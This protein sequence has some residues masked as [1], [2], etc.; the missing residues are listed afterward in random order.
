MSEQQTDSYD[1]RPVTSKKSER[2]PF[3]LCFS[4]NQQIGKSDAC[5]SKTNADFVTPKFYSRELEDP[6]NADVSD[7]LERLATEQDRKPRNLYQLPLLT[8][9][10]YGWWHDKGIHP[11]D[12]RFD[13]HKRTSDLVS[14]QMKIYAEDRSVER[15]S[16]GGFWYLAEIRKD[17]QAGSRRFSPRMSSGIV[18]EHSRLHEKSEQ[19]RPS[20]SQESSLPESK[21]L[22]LDNGCNNNLN[23]TLNSHSQNNTKWPYSG[24]AS[25]IEPEILEDMGVSMLEDGITNCENT[26]RLQSEECTILTENLASN[27]RSVIDDSVIFGYQEEVYTSSSLEIAISD[28]VQ[29]DSCDTDDLTGFGSTENES[30][31]SSRMEADYFGDLK[32]SFTKEK[33]NTSAEKNEQSCLDQ[34][35][36]FRRKKRPSVYGEDKFN[37]LSDEIIL[38]ILKWLPK[39]CLVRSMLVC[40]RWCQIAQDE[41][42]WTRLDMGS[43]VL[44]EGTLGHILP[45]GVQILRLAQAEIADPVFCEGSE[46]LSD[47]YISKLQYLDLSMA[48]I[49]PVGLAVLLSKCKYLKKLSL[50]K[51]IVNRDCCRAISQNT[52]LEVLNLTMCENINIGCIMD[53][54]ELKCLTALNIAWCSLDNECITLLCRTLST[55]I[56]RLNLAGCR[57]TMT[58]ENVK[59]L[60]KRCPDI[61][62][63]DLSD[64]AMLT[65][66]AVHNL[67]NFSKLEHLSLS[68]CYSIPQS[69]YIR[70]A[71][72]PCLL[73]LDVFGL[74]T[75]SVLKSLQA[76]CREPEINKYLYSSVARPTV[77]IRRTSIWGLRV[78]D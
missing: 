38:M 48:V 69:A 58:D 30:G 17:T 43:K 61:I 52:E 11:K 34:F 14:L 4:R 71:T 66:H 7:T 56:T 3:K 16:V 28:R 72:M 40:K 13:F 21:R 55:S 31:Y 32:E 15:V 26:K 53:L 18:I 23:D 12:A 68:R 59:D 29:Q 22:R 62:E 77:G 50:E 25:L 45:R 63:L 37:K 46:V 75:E 44:N 39:K 27:N 33:M 70:L 10:T 65:M 54:M 1:S 9:H 47:S 2:P 5:I 8:S 19:S 57:K 76:A 36:L 67:L 73:Y 42:L 60:L 74:M 51:C 24:D 41:A 6:R 35:C 49:S 20:R 64:C 78:R